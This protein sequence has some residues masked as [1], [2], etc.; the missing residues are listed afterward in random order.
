MISAQTAMYSYGIFLILSAVCLIAV[1]ILRKDI[2][3]YPP[4]GSVYIFLAIICLFLGIVIIRQIEITKTIYIL[5]IAAVIIFWIVA[6]FRL[7][8]RKND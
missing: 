2:W 7:P 5:I 8:T 3:N 6:L 4:I 1:L